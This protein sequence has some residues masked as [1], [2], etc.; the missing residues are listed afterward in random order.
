M[1]MS[2]TMRVVAAAA[3]SS[4][5][6]KKKKKKGAVVIG[7]GSCGLDYLAL[8]ASFPRPDDKIRTEKMEMRG[9][10]NC[11]NALTAAARLGRG[12]GGGGGVGGVAVAAVRPFLV[13]RVGSDGAAA[14]IAGELEADGVSTRF[15][16][17]FS[18]DSDSGSD[19]VPSPTT[20]IIVDRERGTRT[21]IH[22]P[23]PAF[24]AADLEEMMATT[25]TA[26]L[27]APPS[28]A[29][30]EEDDAVEFPSL[31]EALDAASLVFFDGRLAEAALPLA[32]A[33]LER[34]I[35][36][37]VEAERPR[38]GLGELLR[39]ATFVTTSATFPALALA[40]EPGTI[41]T[42]SS[43]NSSNSA[44]PSAPPPH[45]GA[46][47]AWLL[48]ALP[49]SVR[50]VSTTLGGRGAILIERS[51]RSGKGGEGEGEGGEQDAG[52]VVEEA[53][54]LAEEDLR[55]RKTKGNQEKAT[56]ATSSTGFDVGVPGVASLRGVV[57]KLPSSPSPSPSS[58][59]SS[60]ASPRDTIVV[61]VHAS[62]AAPLPAAV[63]DSTGAGDAF[64]GA[65]IHAL[66]TSTLSSPSTSSSSS[67]SE[68]E[69]GEGGGGESLHLSKVLALACVVAGCNCMGLGA[70]GG[71][72]RSGEDVRWE[73][74]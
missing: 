64:N 70:R 74:L 13:S 3:T 43:P 36:I 16:S 34:N 53:L 35:P 57:I 47:A 18:G 46:C 38:E 30:A 5:E 50:W 2:T 8:V 19:V 39:R 69:G 51:N 10:G 28:T 42:S 9:G 66:S 62:T 12:E 61:N 68:E 56:A 26:P 6:D 20:Y 55:R 48:A 33:A 45:P 58:P 23:G 60:I 14:S 29:T 52:A 4:D 71:L 67:T 24:G 49:E 7:L 1:S 27:S 65:L 11:A 22:T 73:L 54:S 41:S 25:T 59:S 15:L 32:D 44:S 21:C 31:S 40:G 72:P 17:R 63:V 37:L